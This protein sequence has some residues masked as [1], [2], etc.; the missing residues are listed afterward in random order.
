MGA[1]MWSLKAM[2]RPPSGRQIRRH[3]SQGNGSWV[4][5]LK[6][7]PEIYIADRANGRLQVYDLE[8]NFKRTGKPEG[9]RNPCCFYQQGGHLYIPDLAA[10]V[11]V[12]DKN[13][14]SSPPSATAKRCRRRKRTSAPSSSPRT[15]SRSTARATLRPRVDPYRRVPKFATT[16]A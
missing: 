8:L 10:Q 14:S 2:L 13:T 12:L 9:L 1:G 3:F 5:T 4:N 7:E 16:P 6:P 11:L 15:P